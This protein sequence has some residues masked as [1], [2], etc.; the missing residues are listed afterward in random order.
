MQILVLKPNGL[1]VAGYGV[2]ATVLAVAIGSL[3]GVAGAKGSVDPIPRGSESLAP[4]KVVSLLGTTVAAKTRT[5]S[6]IPSD[7]V[8][9][10]HGVDGVDASSV[11][12]L[13]TGDGTE[14][15][16]AADNAGNICV[17]T[18]LVE[19][20]VYASACNTPEAAEKN[21]VSVGAFDDP[22]RPGYRGITALL[23]PDSAATSPRALSRSVT[24]WA[25]L[26]PNLV[27]SD[28]ADIQPGKAYEFGRVSRSDEPV[29]FVLD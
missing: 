1:R 8:L 25:A 10:M 2:L 7:A 5:V 28:T 26:S 16:A 19:Q 12:L 13:G 24:P 4:A 21:G 23:L 17:I 27:V 18:H 14:F 15:W 6:A 29:E 11:R 20:D 3:I 22:T 9:A